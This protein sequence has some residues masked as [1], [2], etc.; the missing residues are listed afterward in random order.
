MVDSDNLYYVKYHIT[1]EGPRICRAR[2]GRCP[3]S[4]ESH[5]ESRF[6]SDYEQKKWDQ[7]VRQK[8]IDSGEFPRGG[9]SLFSRYKTSSINSLH[10][11]H[12]KM[13]ALTEK[14]SYY[15]AEAEVM[16]PQG[17]LVSK[18]TSMKL[19][20]VKSW[21]KDEEEY[22]TRISC[23]LSTPTL[24]NGLQEQSIDSNL[25]TRNE[26]RNFKT[27]LYEFCQLGARQSFS[28][29][30]LARLNAEKMYAD[31]SSV[32]KSFVIETTTLGRGKNFEE[33]FFEY[34]D[35]TLSVTAD[36]ALSTFDPD[37]LHQELL[38]DSR[39]ESKVP[40]VEIHIYDDRAR[41]SKA[42]WSLSREN[43]KWGLKLVDRSGK[44]QDIPITDPAE[45]QKIVSEFTQSENMYFDE[46]ALKKGQYVYDLITR[47]ESSLNE[48]RERNASRPA[49]ALDTSNLPPV[50]A[51]ESQQKPKEDKSI[52]GK[53]FKLFS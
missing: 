48:L 26:N 53:I 22:E 25:D 31:L 52:L 3:Y 47:T 9:T 11:L 12:E 20:I 36:Q 43:G 41:S 27:K 32:H 34:G 21:D 37:H 5:F 30:E 35:N 44:A 39:W 2:P 23:S 40:E 18:P 19:K 13:R 29:P 17:D 42:S 49:P 50:S 51:P 45:A 7:A 8:K 15:E 33:D 46:L 24:Y 38:E 14:Q 10:T 1:S 4:E 6:H 28:D 16:F